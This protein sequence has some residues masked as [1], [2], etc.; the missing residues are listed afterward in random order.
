[1]VFPKDRCG[2]TI[3]VKHIMTPDTEP[4]LR[5]D[6]APSRAKRLP[7][8]VE[9]HGCADFDADG[10]TAKRSWCLL[11]RMRMLAESWSAQSR[12]ARIAQDT[13]AHQPPG[14]DF[15]L[16]MICVV[17]LIIAT[18]SATGLV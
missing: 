17:V 7:D 8:I 15:A 12:A 16:I 11:Q 3:T 2:G 5:S 4:H 14:L 1:M 18:L 9:S 10:Q 13:G 6:L